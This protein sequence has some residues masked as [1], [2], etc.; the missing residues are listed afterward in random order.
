MKSSSD[1]SITNLKFNM[2]SQS[3]LL[4]GAGGYI[5][6]VISQEFL[7]QKSKFARV[8]ILADASKVD[9]FAEIS[10]KGIEIV[11]GSFL[12]PNSFKGKPH[13]FTLSSLQPPP[14]IPK[15][16]SSKASPP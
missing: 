15:L 10:K 12:E 11:V 2:S 1:E 4:I 16:T 7:T 14:H 5:D 3:V 13:P 8:A 6:R 9:K